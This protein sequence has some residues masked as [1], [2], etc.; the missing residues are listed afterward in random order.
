MLCRALPVSI[1][2]G[3][4]V[5]VVHAALISLLFVDNAYV[6]E[7]PPASI[8]VAILSSPET[9]SPAFVER[10]VESQMQKKLQSDVDFKPMGAPVSDRLHE[11]PQSSELRYYELR[12]LT[13][14]PLVKVD[15]PTELLLQLDDDAP[16]VAI[17]SL[18][19]NEYGDVDRVDIDTQNALPKLAAGKLQQVFSRAMFHPGERDGVPVKS[20]MRIVVR[21]DSPDSHFL[22]EKR[23]AE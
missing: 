2:F 14:K 5:A 16:Q 8:R 21:L 23:G 7:G 15:V 11:H 1:L 18:W 4:L 20:H 13:Q 6:S 19:I 17:L 3:G 9:R 22:G 10:P 12:E